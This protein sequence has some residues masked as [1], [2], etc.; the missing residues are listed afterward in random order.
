MRR[1]FTLFYLVATVAS[2]RAEDT[3]QVSG[4]IDGKHLQFSPEVRQKVVTDSVSLLASCCY[5]S[6]HDSSTN[7]LHFEDAMKQSHLRIIFPKPQIVEVQLDEK[8]KVKVKE[9]V[10]TLPLASAAI[11]VRS[12][13]STSY[14]AKFTPETLFKL[15]ASLKEAQKP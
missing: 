3:A 9:L 8:M 1:L 10:I 6:L 5:S 7:T 14:F 4:V 15:Q 13:D 12:D 11:W 2:A